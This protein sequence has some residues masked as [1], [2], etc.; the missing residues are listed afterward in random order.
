MFP[1]GAVDELTSLCLWMPSW[2]PSFVSARADE[3]ESATVILEDVQSLRGRPHA[4]RI[5]FLLSPSSFLCWGRS[6][7]NCLVLLG[8]LGGKKSR[9]IFGPA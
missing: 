7:Q 5:I 3:P 1:L 8:Y 9:A 6:K 2:N 4:N